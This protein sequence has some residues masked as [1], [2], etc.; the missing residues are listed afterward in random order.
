DM[1][2]LIEESDLD[3]EKLENVIINNLNNDERLNKM[4]ENIKSNWS[5]RAVSSIVDDITEV[6]GKK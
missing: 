6:L 3:K 5:A 2:Y 1:A 4:R